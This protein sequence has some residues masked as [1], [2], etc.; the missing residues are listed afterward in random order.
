ML[1]PVWDPLL[2]T[3]LTSSISKL[4]L[5]AAFLKG[6]NH[7]LCRQITR[8]SISSILLALIIE[9]LKQK[10][11]KH[12]TVSRQFQRDHCHEIPIPSKRKKITFSYLS[13]TS[14][15]PPKISKLD[16]PIPELMYSISSLPLLLWL[17]NQIFLLQFLTV[18]IPL[19]CFSFHTPPFWYTTDIVTG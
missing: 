4:L 13:K 12:I 3:A 18:P 16:S 15:K 10:S 8:Y 17:D 2:A 11:S 14:P 1:C 7:D 9:L 6:N 19:S 5:D